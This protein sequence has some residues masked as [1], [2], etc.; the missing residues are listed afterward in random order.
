M[1]LNFSSN[2]VRYEYDSDNLLGLKA[3]VV[4]G[5]NYTYVFDGDLCIF[6]GYDVMKADQKN[7]IVSAFRNIPNFTPESV[8]FNRKSDDSCQSGTTFLSLAD[9]VPEIF[10]QRS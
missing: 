5:R 7:E 4:D 10:G 3:T 8:Y 2:A 6:N 1:V 9:N